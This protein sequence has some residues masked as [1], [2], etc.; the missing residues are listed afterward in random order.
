MHTLL[1]LAAVT[2]AFFGILWAI[3]KAWE[4]VFGRS[5]TSDPRDN[6]DPTSDWD[7]P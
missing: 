5:G 4:A 7:G 2:A 1:L 6:D 3:G